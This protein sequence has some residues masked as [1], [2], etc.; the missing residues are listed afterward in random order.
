MHME[1]I[2]IQAEVFKVIRAN[3]GKSRLE[4]I[5]LI[6]ENLPNLTTQELVQALKELSK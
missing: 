2:E 1:T 4:I 6:R 5:K 3:Q